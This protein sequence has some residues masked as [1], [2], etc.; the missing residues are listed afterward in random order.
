[1]EVIYAASGTAVI[2]TPDYYIAHVSGT[3]EFCNDRISIRGWGVST[4]SLGE[5]R[6][7]IMLGRITR[8][9]TGKSLVPRIPFIFRYIKIY[10]TLR[11][12]TIAF[13]GWK[14]EGIYRIVDLFKE[15]GI[16]VEGGGFTIIY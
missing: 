10:R 14:K 13:A 15:H 9:S 2:E 5:L 12:N 3:F 8:V 1:M 4:V 6:Q 11:E 16:P 7:D